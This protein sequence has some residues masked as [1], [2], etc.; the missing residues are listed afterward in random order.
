MVYLDG[1]KQNKKFF[2][3]QFKQDGADD[4]RLW[5]AKNR[6][7]DITAAQTKVVKMFLAGFFVFS[8]SLSLSLATW[9]LAVKINIREQQAKGDKSMYDLHS[10]NVCL[11]IY[12]DRFL[13]YKI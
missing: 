11:S 5:P 9:E 12:L 2:F 10:V 13:R 8:L 6:V 4:W 1:A 3:L 7:R